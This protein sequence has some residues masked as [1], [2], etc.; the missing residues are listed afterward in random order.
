MVRKLIWLKSHYECGIREDTVPRS[1]FLIDLSNLLLLSR[2]SQE[3]TALQK[4][5]AGKQKNHTMVF[6]F[7]YYLEVLVICRS[8]QEWIQ[9]SKT[10]CSFCLYI[11]NKMFTRSHRK[12][13]CCGIKHGSFNLVISSTILYFKTEYHFSEFYKFYTFWKKQPDNVGECLKKVKIYN[14]TV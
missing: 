8:R 4:S 5:F 13:W 7:W 12:I 1:V 2:I 9:A 10:S 14:S 6:L 11:I 3:T